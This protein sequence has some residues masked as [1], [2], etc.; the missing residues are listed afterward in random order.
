MLSINA[1][2][3]FM[4]WVLIDKTYRNLMVGKLEMGLGIRK[5]NSEGREAYKN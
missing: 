4:Y 3:Y 5:E 2:Y 1:I